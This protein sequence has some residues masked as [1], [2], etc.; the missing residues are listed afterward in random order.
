MEEMQTKRTLYAEQILDIPGS[1]VTIR[2]Y[3]LA[4]VFTLSTLLVYVAPCLRGQ[5]TLLHLYST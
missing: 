1:M 5:C 2:L 3:K 4:N